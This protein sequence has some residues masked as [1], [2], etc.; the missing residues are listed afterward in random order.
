[1]SHP[2]FEGC[3]IQPLSSRVLHARQTKRCFLSRG[4]FRSDTREAERDRRGPAGPLSSVEPLG[5]GAI[6]LLVPGMVFSVFET[7][8]ALVAV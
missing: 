3:G 5:S 2:P 1:M 4:V 7:G 8:G 6:S